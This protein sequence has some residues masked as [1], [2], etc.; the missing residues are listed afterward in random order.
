MMTP[1]PIHKRGLYAITP[2][3]SDAEDLIERAGLVLAGG[4]VWLQYRDKPV[5]RPELARRLLALC[6]RH[7]ALFIV[8]DDPE[9]A[10]VV[11]ADG[12]HLGRDDPGVERARVL[13]GRE[14]IIGVSC[15][16]DLERAAA[17]AGQGPDYLA[18]GGVY[19]SATKPD[20]VSCPL[21][22]ITA[23]RRFGLPL[24][25]IGGITLERA[26]EVIAA[27]AHFVAVSSDVF[28][29][30]DIKARAAGYAELFDLS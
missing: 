12:V 24:A 3:Q 15:Y 29:A 26:P 16:N 23:A 2:V 25:A 20:A 14:R 17:L 30:P 22:R 19:P 5:P 21:E 28:G 10:A 27:G 6:R 1:G 8:N 9:L 4:A 18:F 11:G 7:G 13:L